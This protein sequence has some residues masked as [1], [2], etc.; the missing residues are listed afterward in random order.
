MCLREGECVLL[1]GKERG[2]KRERDRGGGTVCQRTRGGP[3]VTATWER[4]EGGQGMGID[5]ASRELLPCALI[6]PKH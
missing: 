2:Q 1:G 6:K 4:R 3:D 5:A